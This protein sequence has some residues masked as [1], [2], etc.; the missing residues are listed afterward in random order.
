MNDN[1]YKFL[2]QKELR[3]IQNNISHAVTSFYACI[4]FRTDKEFLDRDQRL[5]PDVRL[6]MR[7]YLE[8]E[9]LLTGEFDQ[10]GNRRY[11]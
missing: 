9:D 4:A 6:L 10:N 8:I 2:S 7:R 3:E 5:D 11:V 1:N